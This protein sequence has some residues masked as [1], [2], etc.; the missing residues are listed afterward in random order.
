MRKYYGFSHRYGQETCD[1]SG[2]SIGNIMIFSSRK[3]RDEWVDDGPAYSS[4]PGFREE[5][6]SRQVKW[7]WGEVFPRGKW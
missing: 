2:Y 3:E 1:S 5:L 7:Q 6:S 4:E